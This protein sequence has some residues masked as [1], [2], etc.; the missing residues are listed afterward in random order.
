LDAK[1]GTYDEKLFDFRVLTLDTVT[2]GDWSLEAEVQAGK[3]ESNFC[4]LAFGKKDQQNFH[5][6]MFF[7][8]RTEASGSREGLAESGFVDLASCFGNATFKT[9]RHNPVKGS[10]AAKEMGTT[11]AGAP[12]H[13]LRIDVADNLVDTWFDGEFLAT[14]EFPSPD[15]LR[16]N[17]GLIVGPGAAKCRGVRFLARPA[18]DPAA[19][20][21]R[22][23][24]MEK[25]EAEAGPPPGGS[26]LG[27]VPP[28]PSVEKWVQGSR[29]DWKEKGPVPQLLVFWSTQQ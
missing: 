28:L 3:G 16:G 14:Q 5:G 19:R 22:A 1:F 2:S 23:V 9:W 27:R 24:R 4:G 10:P 26:Y 21:D 11:T 7:P 12:W 15:P 17:L 20:I 18:R 6:L 25:I 13:K 29:N 8:G